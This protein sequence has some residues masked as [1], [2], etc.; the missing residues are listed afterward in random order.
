M[1]EIPNLA[2]LSNDDYSELYKNLI[3][4][5]K[6][7]AINAKKILLSE[8][9]ETYPENG[10]ND[11]KSAF[12]SQF[13]DI[14]GDLVLFPDDE[15]INKLK[16]LRF[17]SQSLKWFV[18]LEDILNEIERLNNINGM[19]FYPYIYLHAIALHLHTKLMI[20][21]IE[22]FGL[23]V[24]YNNAETNILYKLFAD[25]FRRREYNDKKNQIAKMDYF[26]KQIN[27]MV[28]NSEKA[29]GSKFLFKQ[30][31]LQ[32]IKGNTSQFIF[33]LDV[34]VNK[35]ISRSKCY[36]ELYPLLKLILKDSKFLSEEDYYAS[37]DDK[38]AANY[39]NYKLARVKRI[40]QKK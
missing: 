19:N 32:H 18:K 24:F 4:N 2:D 36:I 30:L 40:F 38:Y 33:L 17:S 28:D 39:S 31:F 27:T 3:D 15:V 14:F 16:E 8:Q 35:E 26:E 6:K 25:L 13:T 22:G 20:S 37:K 11:D 1:I 34:F 29:A 12:L 21:S 7:N 9:F 10:S 5:L 23:N